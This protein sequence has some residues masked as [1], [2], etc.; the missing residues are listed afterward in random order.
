MHFFFYF[1]YI[2]FRF[3]LYRPCQA[4]NI[5]VC[6]QPFLHQTSK[7]QTQIHLCAVC[8]ILLHCGLYHP[9]KN[10]PLLKI[11]EEKSNEFQVTGDIF[12]DLR[13]LIGNLRGSQWPEA[14]TPCQLFNDG[15]QCSKVCRHNYDS[16][17]VH[18]C[19]ECYKSFGC[20]F[21][22][23]AKVTKRTD[24]TSVE[25]VCPVKKLSNHNITNFDDE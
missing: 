24:G 18:M 21:F 5:D 16:K 17:A 9:V 15:K 13:N 11:H 10:C 4:F 19:S 7:G 20:G 23:P 3:T 2:T 22:H 12:Q 14:H 8:L 1:R 6:D 25:N